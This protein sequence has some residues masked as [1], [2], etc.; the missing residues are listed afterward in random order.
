MEKRELRVYIG[1][2]VQSEIQ[3]HL[4]NDQILRQYVGNP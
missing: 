3:A 2:P 4:C 1:V